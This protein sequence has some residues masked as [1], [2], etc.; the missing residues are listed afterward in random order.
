M[1]GMIVELKDEVL[2]LQIGDKLEYNRDFSVLRVR[3]VVK[4]LKDKN[5]AFVV[6]QYGTNPIDFK[7]YTSQL[8]ELKYCKHGW[9]KEDVSPE[10]RINQSEY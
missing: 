3:G 7:R 9:V 6:F 4:E 10:G 1:G 5:Q 2:D 8:T